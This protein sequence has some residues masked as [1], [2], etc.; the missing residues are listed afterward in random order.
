MA[1]EEERRGPIGRLL[2]ALGRPFRRKTTPEPMMPLW[3]AGIQEPVLVQGV[4]IPALYATVQ[5][6]VILRTTIQTLAQE[7]FRRGY[8]WEKKYHKKCNVCL[9]EYQHDT[10]EQCGVCDSMDFKTPDPDE[11]IYPRWMFEQRNSMDQSFFDV[12]KEIEWDLDIVD[13]AFLI[14]V[15]EYFI[16]PDSGD[17]EF[18]RV[19]EILR[20][21]PTFFRL[22]ADKRGVRGG[23][24][25]VC[26]V[27]RDKTYPHSSPDNHT[28]CEV[29]KLPLQDVHYINTAGAGK[30]QYYLDNEVVHISKF[31]PSKLY[32][33]SPVATMWRQAMTLTAMDNYMYLSYS[34][35]RIPRGVLAITTDNIQSTASFWKGAEEKMERDPHYIPKVG[36]ESATGRG[37]VEFVRFMDTLDEMQYAQ[38]RDELRM[39]IAA[40]YGVSNIFM[41]DSGKGGGLNNEGMQILVTNRAVEFG[42]KI[43]TRDLFPRMLKEMGVSDWQITLYPNEEEDDVTRLRRDEM[44]VNIAQRMMQL[45]FQ[46]ELKEDAA[47]DIR[48]VYKRPE[49]QPPGMEGQQPPGGGMPGGGGGMPPGGGAPPTGAPPPGGMPQQPIPMGNMMNPAR[50]GGVPI[51]GGSATGN[52]P[53]MMKAANLGL[54]EGT[55][56]RDRGPAPVE[57]VQ[58]LTGHPTGGKKGQRGSEKTPIEQALDSIEAAKNPKEG[59][60]K[61]SNLP[62]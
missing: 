40:F 32:G 46:P 19:K 30:T 26:P 27:H 2:S 43:Y 51:G 14:L 9:E 12:M 34:K 44:E 20:G 55:G 6:S 1:G 60:Q 31:N 57:N 21:D 29:C 62:R 39:R 47:R 22:V 37:K 42:Q 38:V 7:I 61:D 28:K 36:V 52:V 24:Y 11:I 33:R 18:F 13:D 5:E 35:R 8:Y 59:K 53:A 41:M 49:P 25:L 56:Q 15:K 10:I 50:S 54:G 23:R 16:D 45:G 17:I 3:K 4:S 48:F 58:G